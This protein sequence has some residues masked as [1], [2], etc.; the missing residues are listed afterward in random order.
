MFYLTH[1]P[2]KP[3]NYLEA[4]IPIIVVFKN[5]WELILSSFIEL[6][7]QTFNRWGLFLL[8]CNE[9]R[10]VF[11]SDKPENIVCGHVRKFVTFSIN[12]SQWSSL[13]RVHS[14]CFHDEIQSEVHLNI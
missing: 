13:I 14:D 12:F 4:D 10:Y 11:T 3:R 7:D 5:A 2:L 6:T 9:K 8:A 1:K